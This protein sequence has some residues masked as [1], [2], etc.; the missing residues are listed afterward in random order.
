MSM[1]M[2]PMTIHPE[3]QVGVEPERQ[4]PDCNTTI[5]TCHAQNVL[6]LPATV[7]S[8]FLKRCLSAE[9]TAA[10]CSAAEL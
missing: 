3:V 2:Q 7:S 10:D 6:L 5:S 9:S 4:E 1:L 8:T